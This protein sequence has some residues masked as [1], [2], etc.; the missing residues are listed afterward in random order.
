VGDEGATTVS[1]RFRLSNLDP[2]SV[3]MALLSLGNAVP[4]SCDAKNGA[5]SLAIRDGSCDQSAVSPRGG[6]GGRRP[7]SASGNVGV[8]PARATTAPNRR[9]EGGCGGHGGRP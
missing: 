8:P 9:C 5:I 6:V 4:Y 3:G 7:A 2:K 1:A